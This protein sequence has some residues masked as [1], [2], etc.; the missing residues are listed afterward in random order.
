MSKVL[1]ITFDTFNSKFVNYNWEGGLFYISWPQCLYLFKWRDWNTWSLMSSLTHTFIDSM[2]LSATLLMGG[3]FSEKPQSC[4]SQELWMGPYL[5]IVSRFSEKTQSSNK[6]TRPVIRE[7]ATGIS[8]CNSFSHEES[9][10]EEKYKLSDYN[11]GQSNKGSF[12][13]FGHKLKL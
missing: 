9:V 11:L 7:L 1:R 13:C 8:R 3:Q 10:S 6:I 4:S 2:Y 5:P 12:K